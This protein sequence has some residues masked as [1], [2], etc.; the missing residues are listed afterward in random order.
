MIATVIGS[1]TCVPSRLRGSPCVLVQV[2]G[3]NLLCDTGP[4]SLRQLLNAGISI[5]DIDVLVYTHFHIDHTADFCPFLFAAKYGRGVER[6]RPLTVMGPHGLLQ[7]Y[8]DLTRVYGRWIVPDRFS[9]DWVESG[10]G[11]RS[12]DGFTVH[13]VPVRHSGPSNAVRIHETGGSSLAY[14]GDT[15]YCEGIV[16]ACRD[17]GKA[18]L[19][20]SC[21][22][23]QKSE[24]HLTPSLAGIIARE[25][26]CGGIVLTHIYPE[27]DRH[28]L[29]APV[30]RHYGGPVEI[31]HD[32]MS[33]SL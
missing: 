28:D 18:I 10:C 33:F 22:E 29:L 32:M 5:E 4:G 8:D 30:R 15:D 3:S 6:T 9:I 27:T 13:T 11:S 26:N 17:T 21:P 19:E 20:C 16:A 7:W 14:S 12:F 25:S 24:G 1:G 31:A 23:G 2:A